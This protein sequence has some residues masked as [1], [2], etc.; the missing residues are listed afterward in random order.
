MTCYY[1][2]SLYEYTTIYIIYEKVANYKLTTQHS[3]T[4]L[5]II[6]GTLALVTYDGLYKNIYVNA[7]LQ[8]LLTN[9]VEVVEHRIYRGTIEYIGV[10]A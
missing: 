7:M 2:W 10:T 6:L 4:K 9:H 3:K 5:I 8:F 1:S